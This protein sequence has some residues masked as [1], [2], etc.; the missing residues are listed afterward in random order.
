MKDEPKQSYEESLKMID[1][2]MDEIVECKQVLSELRGLE[3]K[4]MESSLKFYQ[5]YYGVKL[6]AI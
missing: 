6:E 3:V 5:S 4:D 1:G 2:S